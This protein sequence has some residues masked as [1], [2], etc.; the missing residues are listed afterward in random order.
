[1]AI[2]TDL[3]RHLSTLLLLSWEVVVLSG[4]CMMT[5]PALSLKIP[6]PSVNTCSTRCP[7][8]CV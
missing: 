1:M 4:N 7:R 3:T 6:R 8:D 2:R 5:A